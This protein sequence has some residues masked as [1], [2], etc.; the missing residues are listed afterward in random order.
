M[1]T[2]SNNPQA[3]E[4]KAIV[5]TVERLVQPTPIQIEQDEEGRP[6]VVKVLAIPRG[7]TLQSLKP[8]E[9]ERR[10]RP[11]RRE[12]TATHTT[13]ESFC[14]AVE[15][16]SDAQS[17][18]FAHDDPK[19]PR[20][21][22]IFDYHEGNERADDG[23]VTDLGK[24]R[25]GKHRAVYPFPLSPEWLAWSGLAQQDLSQRAL[26]E[27]L[28]DHIP[29]VL[30]PARVGDSTRE[31]AEQIGVNLA[32]PSQLLTLSRGLALRVDTKVA[33]AVNL[34]TGEAQFTYDEQHRDKESGQPLRVPNGF[35]ISIPVFRGGHF[36][37]LLVR[38][39]YRVQAGNVSFKAQVHRAEN[40]FRDAFEEACTIAQE[41]T[42]IPLFH[43]SPEA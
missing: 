27:F 14:M 24:P 43:G 5:E 25:F 18:L 13:L 39:R 36:Y 6:R 40:A 8:F 31:L 20:L 34:S 32:T 35:A 26:A 23:S 29:E 37:V 30:D 2:I 21:L 28:E 10:E 16:F 4:A 12:G 17:A 15:R 9:D 7:L 19:S 22:A 41:R 1:E 33:Q 38:L 3:S 11:E 42:G